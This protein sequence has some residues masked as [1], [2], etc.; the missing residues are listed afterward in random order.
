MLQACL[1]QTFWKEGTNVLEKRAMIWK[2]PYVLD[3]GKNSRKMHQEK[4]GFPFL[5]MGPNI[6]TFEK[7]NRIVNK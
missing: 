7:I 5:C 2:C 3:R 6:F 1:R 4:R